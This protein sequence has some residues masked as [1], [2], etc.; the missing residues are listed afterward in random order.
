MGRTPDVGEIVDE[1][2][3]VE[4][5]I[6]SGNFGHVYR[7]TELSSNNTLA[8]K[9]L[10]PGPHDEEELRQRFE[11]EARLI[12]SLQH[13][14]IVR[15]FYYG[16][17]QGGLPYMAM[18]FLRGTDLRTLLHHHGA[19]NHTLVRRIALETLSALSSAHDLGIVHRDL[20]P[21]N[22]FLVNDGHK[23]HVKV[24]DFG[25]AKALDENKQQG[26]ITNAGT[27]V[28][29]PAYMSPELV[30]KRHVGPP[31]DIYAL[32]LILA[33]MITGK[34]II[35]IESVYDT[36]LFQASSK[37]IKLPKEV[38]DS[39]FAEIA[40]RAVAKK[41]TE[42]YSTAAEMMADLDALFIPGSNDNRERV[43]VRAKSAPDPVRRIEESAETIPR[44]DGR[45]D[46]AEIGSDLNQRNTPVPHG[47][48]RQ[49]ES[50]PAIEEEPAFAHYEEPEV[51]EAQ[52]NLRY[53]AEFGMVSPAVREMD[54][55]L[56]TVEYSRS[57]LGLDLPDPGGPTLG[58]LEQRIPAKQ[59]TTQPIMEAPE[60]PQEGGG[61]RGR[62]IFLG[63]F[64]GLLG[65][66]GFAA[67]LFLV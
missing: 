19:L 29:T 6:D 9:V 30:H 8:L 50:I 5:E 56:P 18:E 48:P 64:I 31:A 17:T 40:Q 12:Y 52:V 59:Q 32:G 3:R 37:A 58:E 42:R 34:K 10:K 44:S 55:E 45:P 67:I 28:G 49:T 57:N 41:L 22:I 11:R 65:L 60:L 33:E 24:L 7:V 47:G 15:V 20:K 13:P 51:V 36:I 66:A 14:H 61:I 38:M 62:D 25:F 16:Q 43:P 2:F 23:G 39:P 46:L 21:A 35:Q 27:L 4:A 53:T 26:E 63:I 54:E 1:A